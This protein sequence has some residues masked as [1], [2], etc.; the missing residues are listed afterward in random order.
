[1]IISM[2]SFTRFYFLGIGGIGMSAIARYYQANGFEV[3]GYDRVKTKL[4]EDLQNEGIAVS[5]EEHESSIPGK[6][7]DKN[8]TLVIITPAV[9]EDNLQLI[10]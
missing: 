9:P 10:Y 6:F 7:T 3:A 4:S 8:R 1:M 2:K 5:Y